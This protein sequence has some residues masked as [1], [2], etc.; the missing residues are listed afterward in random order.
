MGVNAGIS[1]EKCVA[2]YNLKPTIPAINYS[3]ATNDD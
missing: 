1:V 3:S 2:F